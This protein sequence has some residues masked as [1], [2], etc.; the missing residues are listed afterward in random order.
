MHISCRFP[1][2]W[3]NTPPFSMKERSVLLMKVI[4]RIKSSNF[5]RPVDVNCIC[6]GHRVIICLENGVGTATISALLI[7]NRKT[8]IYI[9]SLNEI[10]TRS[11]IVWETESSHL[12]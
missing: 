3:S 8:Q 7:I 2:S 1:R 11:P 9:R 12:S 5:Y 10:R 6:R 4:R